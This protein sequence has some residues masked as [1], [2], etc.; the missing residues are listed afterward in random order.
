LNLHT[1]FIYINFINFHNYFIFSLTLIVNSFNNKLRKDKCYTDV[2]LKILHPYC[3]FWS[4]TMCSIQQVI[5]AKIMNSLQRGTDRWHLLGGAYAAA[6]WCR[7]KCY[8]S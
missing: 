7:I 5:K 6:C 2:Q 3:N 4:S 8:I 1:K